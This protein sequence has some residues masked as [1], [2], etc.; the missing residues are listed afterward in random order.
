MKRFL[1]I[2]LV[3][4]PL[5]LSCT[6]KESCDTVRILGV[7]NSWTRDSM[8]YL[9]AIASS[10]GRPVIVGHAYL[11]GSTL[12]DQWH[13]IHDTSYVYIHNGQPQ[14]VHATYQ[15]WKYEGTVDPVKTPSEGYENGL[16]GIGVPLEYAVSD[17]PWDWIVFQPEAT[18]GGDWPRHLGSDA[19]GYSLEALIADV[20][21]MMSPEAAAKVRLALMVPFSYPEVNTDYREKFLVVYN[22]GKT[23]ANQAEWDSLYRKQYK[24]IQ[25]A[26]PKLCRQLKM[27]ACVNVGA[28]IQA[29]RQDP[30]LSRCGYLLQRRQDNTHLADGVPK[31]IA[32]LCYAYSLL[33]IHPEEVTFFTQ[34]ESLCSEA[35]TL[36]YDITE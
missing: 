36:V 33:G 24:Q 27:D 35:K 16:A 14:K 2:V 31:Y 9:S 7:G 30:D 19:D 3:L 21:G 11:G 1:H 8:R 12:E 29:A 13:G 6:G 22:E 26:A 23:P 4:L 18:L 32:S 34:D 28:A 17:E 15:Y 10:A 5:M 20:K 25:Q